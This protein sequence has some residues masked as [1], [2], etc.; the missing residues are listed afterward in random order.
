MDNDHGKIHCMKTI[1]VS[2]FKARCLKL[3]A[4]VREKGE[5][6]LI[7]KRGQPMV[8][9]VPARDGTGKGWVG[10]M[11]GTARIVGDII[12]P[13]APAEEWDISKQ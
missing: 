10:C 12:E 3:M 4:E 1:S 9:V 8:R 7:T 11:E 2:R 5:P 13:A 6:L